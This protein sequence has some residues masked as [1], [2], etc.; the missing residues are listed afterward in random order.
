MKAESKPIRILHIFGVMDRG[1]AETRTMELMRSIEGKRFH[2]EF[3]ALTGKRGEFDDEIER[4]GGRVHHLGLTVGLPIRF[5]SLIMKR[6]YEVLHSHVHYFTAILLLIGWLAGIPRRIAHFRSTGDGRGDGMMRRLRN[7]ILKQLILWSATDVIGVSEASLALSIGSNW[8]NDRRCQVVYSG[9]RLE[10]FQKPV[11]R[12]GVRGEFGIPLDSLL[13]VHVGRQVEEKN[14]VRLMQIF[15][16]L[17]ARLGHAHLILAGKQDRLIEG[18]LREL[19][20]TSG[21]EG[22]VH[23]AGLRQDVGRLL[24]AAD[25][26]IFPSL[27]EGLPGAVLE[28]AAAGLPV[29]ASE[30][31]G[32]IELAG[33]LPGLQLFPLDQSD[34]NWASV[35]VAMLEAD[36]GMSQRRDAFPARFNSSRAEEKFMNLYA[37]AYGKHWVD[38]L[39]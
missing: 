21:L 29:L 14:H 24:S 15:Q 22:H 38:K 25:L 2:F 9:V 28:A 1:G 23:F 6:N 39:T 31:P 12:E 10:D 36:E 17:V 4:L 3:V 13:V 20:R 18:K 33:T 16:K 32:I 34:E 5:F 11:E 37:G 30:I 19:V 27:R 7:Q 8:A 26:M 35:C